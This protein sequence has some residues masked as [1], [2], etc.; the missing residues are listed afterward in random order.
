MHC[1]FEEYDPRDGSVPVYLLGKLEIEALAIV[2]GK[3]IVKAFRTSRVGK[4]VV[5]TYNTSV[6]RGW[7]L[8]RFDLG[9]RGVDW[10]MF[11]P[12]TDLNYLSPEIRSCR[13][14][15]LV[16]NLYACSSK[17]GLLFGGTIYKNSIRPKLSSSAGSAAIRIVAFR[18]S[19]LCIVNCS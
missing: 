2:E 17:R 5:I 7:F 15:F 13:R 11:P 4:N 8:M 14:H 18:P 19:S 16:S 9:E 6:G 3:K 12:A 10:D 1:Y